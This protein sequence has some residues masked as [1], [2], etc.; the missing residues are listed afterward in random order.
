MKK[1][2][3]I[4]VL[5]FIPFSLFC[6]K[7][8]VSIEKTSY[9]D[10]NNRYFH[11]L[12]LPVYLYL[13]FSPD[14]QP[15]QISTKDY[16]NKPNPMAP[17]YFNKH[18]KHSINYQTN[19]S[20]KSQTVDFVVYA[21][22]YSP[23]TDIKFDGG[24]PYSCKDKIFYANNLAVNLYSED[25]MSGLSATFYSL[26]YADFNEYSGI[27]T[28]DKEGEYV[29][30]YTSADNVGNVEK[31]HKKT[32]SIDATPPST[33]HN[34]I[35]V[36]EGNVISNKTK[37]YLTKEDVSSGIQQTYYQLDKS[38]WQPYTRGLIPISTLNDG[39]HIL[40]YF[41]VDNVGNKENVSE[42]AFYLDKTS[43]IM[44]ADII[45]DKFIVNERV[46]FSGRT[47]M[48]LTA[49]DN[50]SGV[51]EVLYSIDKDK[52]IKYTDPFYLPN[53][54][55]DHIIKY[56]ALDNMAN[57]GIGE[58]N[59][60]YE[61]YTHNSS[62]VYVDLLG[63]KLD[64]EFEGP[65][66]KKGKNIFINKNTKIRLSATD[67][68]SGLKQITYSIN[69]S[70]EEINY[71]KPFEIASEG[72][73][74]LNFF[75]YDNVNNRNIKKTNFIV[76]NDGPEVISTFSISSTKEGE[77]ELYP[78]Y[79]I[80]YLAATDDFIGN[81]YITYAVNGGEELPYKGGIKG[82]EKNKEYIITIKAVD[83]LGNKTVEELS[84]KTDKY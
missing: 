70:K 38:P 79:S 31:I 42:Y 6:Q 4:S 43:P 22:G 44:A 60:A 62:V 48:K 26:N 71:A 40:R 35:G 76:D 68:E 74:T 24:K 64:F 61:E 32:F 9:V 59:T 21:D 83:K 72:R 82:F 13:S 37:V 50:K 51:K 15:T 25:D 16:G 53:K 3:K 41:S 30:Q 20:D 45:G 63:P 75:G 84:F 2:F 10:T 66:F 18:G 39:D 49:V 34:V 47:K 54:S 17:F 7:L 23:K 19:E 81:D 55:G 12:Y 8:P 46:Y 80:V 52:F 67:S 69:E 14:V 65:R 78:S 36:A 1:L 27:L 11:N 56:Y 57:K 33:Y 73:I 58:D 29:L 77:E 28:F 5:F